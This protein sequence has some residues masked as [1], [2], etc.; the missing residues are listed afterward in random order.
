MEA[1]TNFFEAPE[2]VRWL[3]L[4]DPD[5]SYFTTDLCHCQLMSNDKEF[6]CHMRMNLQLYEENQICL[7][8]F[9]GT[10]Q[11]VQLGPSEH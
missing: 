8:L 11:N 2:T 10:G 6:H 9:Q 3:D 7:A 5:S 1:K 4:T